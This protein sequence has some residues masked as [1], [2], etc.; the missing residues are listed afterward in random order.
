[1]FTATEI[2]TIEASEAD[3]D[4]HDW[5]DADDLYLIEQFNQ[6]AATAGDAS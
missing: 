1:M 2:S 6:A 4:E 3:R 5:S